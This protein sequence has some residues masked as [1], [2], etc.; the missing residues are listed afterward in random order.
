[1]TD[2][3]NPAGFDVAT[4][5]AGSGITFLLAAGITR[6]GDRVQYTTPELYGIAGGAFVGIGAVLGIVLVLVGLR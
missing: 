5:L 6:Y 3:G 4:V 1:M 2:I